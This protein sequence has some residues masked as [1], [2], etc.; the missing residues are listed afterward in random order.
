VLGAECCKRLFR[1]CHAESAV[2][3]PMP[4]ARCAEMGRAVAM[5]RHKRAGARL[6]D[7]WGLGH[8]PDSLGSVQMDA[9]QLRNAFR[10]HGHAI[11][12]PSRHA[13]PRLGCSFPRTEPIPRTH[14][15]VCKHQQA[16]SARTVREFGR[17][18]PRPPV[19]RW[20]ATA[21]GRH[22]FSAITMPAERAARTAIDHQNCADSCNPRRLPHPAGTIDT[23]AWS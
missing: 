15:R 5:G 11:W 14:I 1:C 13:L 3:V 10:P 8:G 6:A 4:S 19:C 22:S 12:W 23:R 7:R 21:E 16:P 18:A 20:S 9:W 2:N 17:D